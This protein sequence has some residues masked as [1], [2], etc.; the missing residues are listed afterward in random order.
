[1]HII[2]ILWDGFTYTWGHFYFSNGNNMLFSIINFIPK[3]C[4]FSIENRLTGIKAIF[5][6]NL[7]PFL[8]YF[9]PQKSSG[10]LPRRQPRGSTPAPPTH[11]P[12]EKYQSTQPASDVINILTSTVVSWFSSPFISGMFTSVYLVDIVFY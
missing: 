12:M 11:A 7:R 2:S 3:N 6:Y 1:M 8:L 4:N 5:D 9:G 10:L